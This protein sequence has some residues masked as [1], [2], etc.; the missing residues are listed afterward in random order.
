M[1]IEPRHG[2]FRYIDDTFFKGD[3]EK[4]GGAN[5]KDGKNESWLTE[6]GYEYHYP[7]RHGILDS[8]GLDNAV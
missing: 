4:D 5:S 8:V 6:G 3:S 2:K 1:I 7:N